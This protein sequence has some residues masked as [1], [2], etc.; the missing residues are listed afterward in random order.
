[1]AGAGDHV[2]AGENESNVMKAFKVEKNVPS[3]IFIDEIDSVPK[4]DKTHG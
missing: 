4:T 3:I 2:M 1:M